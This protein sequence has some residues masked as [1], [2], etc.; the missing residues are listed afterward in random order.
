MPTARASVSA[1]LILVIAMSVENIKQQTVKQI[2]KLATKL[3]RNCCYSFNVPPSA[4]SK[5]ASIIKL[6]WSSEKYCKQPNNA[7][8][9]GSHFTTMRGWQQR[10]RFS[11]HWALFR[12]SFNSHAH[13]FPLIKILITQTNTTCT[14]LCGFCVARALSQIYMH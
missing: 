11:I 14:L 1:S 2:T 3:K 4:C 5:Q 7:T 6:S 9:C 12:A 13:S 10:E 8:H